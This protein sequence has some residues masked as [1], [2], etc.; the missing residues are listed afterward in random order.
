MLKLPAR[1]LSKYL[2]FFI[3]LIF[4]SCK[5]VDEAEIIGRYG[6]DKFVSNTN[7]PDFGSQILVIMEDHQFQ[8]TSRDSIILQGEW[9]ILHSEYRN[10]SSGIPQPQAA[11]EFSFNR[12][13]IISDFRSSIFYFNDSETFEPDMDKH[14]LYVKLMR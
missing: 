3:G 12:K 5:E 8:L 4:S 2:I 10:S 7:A 14:I 11:I 9:K 1:F 6:S 13:K